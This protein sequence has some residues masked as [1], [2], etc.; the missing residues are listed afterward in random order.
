[1]LDMEGVAGLIRTAFKQ[2]NIDPS[3]YGI[4]VRE[5]FVVDHSLSSFFSKFPLL[6][7][8]GERTKTPEP[9]DPG[10]TGPSPV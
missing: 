2:L 5:S 7:I 3:S 6:V 9:C 4:Q 10:G 1:M 8:I